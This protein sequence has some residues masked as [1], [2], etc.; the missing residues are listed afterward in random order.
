MNLRELLKNIDCEVYGD[1]N[2]EI[3]NLTHNSKVE[4]INGLFFA[5]NGNNVNGLDYVY[6]A[7]EN[8]AKV[9]V[10]EEK[11]DENI[12]NVVVKDARKA[13]S[14]IAK[15]FYFSPADKL[16][17]VGVTGTNGK[18]TTTY[19]L[20][21]IFE[22]AGKKVGVIGTN[23]IMINNK[24]YASDFTTPDPILLQKTLS[25]M[26][27]NGVDIV[28]ME[29]SAHALELQKLW[30]IMTDIA[31]FT[32]L[33]QDH[34]DYFK[35]MN[36]Y[37]E[38]K[39]KYFTRD[40]ARFGVVN[41]DDPYGKIIYETSEIPLISYSKV[42]ES[43]SDIKAEDIKTKS[44]G[45]EF[46]VKSMKGDFIINLN[47]LGSFNVSNALGAITAAIM[48]GVDIK[49]IQSALENLEKVDGRFNSYFINGAR[50]IVDYAHTPDGLENI[51]KSAREFTENRLISVF[52]CGGNRDKGKRHIM[53]EISTSLADLTIITSDNPRFEDPIDII[54]DVE[55]GVVSGDYLLETDRITAIKK[56][57]NIAKQGDT[58]VIS[59]KGAENYFDINGE[60][61][62]YKTDAGIIQEVQDEKYKKVERESK[63]L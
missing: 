42:K 57:L 25:E 55:R 2:I 19:M 39:R 46:M 37:F 23:G 6:E 50:V 14:L 52:G 15:E 21:S 54:E 12:T 10:S 44:S 13:M 20:K 29:T 47:M 30:G 62:P 9:V 8:G 59:G 5:L 48:A 31:L 18:T 17:I 22:K 7:I 61:I 32:N 3:E 35:N 1:E 43:Q 24:K 36:N 16:F 49:D 34:L 11:I 26:V 56:A 45:Q 4:N 58:I 53:G 38:A 60:K 28:C 33:S 40:Y 27:E 41:I 63:V 51:L